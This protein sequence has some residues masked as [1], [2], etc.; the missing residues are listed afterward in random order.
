MTSPHYL[1]DFASPTAK[2]DF[3]TIPFPKF[4]TPTEGGLFQKKLI[5]S[6]AAP[7]TLKDTFDDFLTIHDPAYQDLQYLLDEHHEIELRAI[8]IAVDFILKDGSDDIDRLTKLHTMLK[9]RLFPQ[10]HHLMSSVSR[11][12]F[13]DLGDKKIK[14]DT[15]ETSSGKESVYWSNNKG[16]EQVR[17]YIKTLDHGVPVK[18]QHSVRLEVTLN[19]GG[20]QNVYIHRIGLLP[21]FLPSIRRYL[22]PY[23][24]VAKGI[25]PVIERCRSA[26]PK[27]VKKAASKV[28]KERGRVDRNWTRYGA[29]WAAKHHY[30]VVPDTDVTRPIGVA[31]KKLREKLKQLHLPAKV[32]DPASWIDEQRSI[33]QTVDESPMTDI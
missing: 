5:G 26:D 25:R 24:T 9:V 16:T 4:K 12:K 7:K 17:L 3:V 28:D 15:L 21:S 1:S 29:Q 11:R 33:Y 22:S 8:E 18:G 32:A 19:R 6:I 27:R 23:L 20:C 30:K 31:L 14:R 13:Y 2:I 10:S